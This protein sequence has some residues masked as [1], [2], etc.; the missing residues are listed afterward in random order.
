[1]FNRPLLPVPPPCNKNII[2]NFDLKQKPN[3]SSDL[4]QGFIFGDMLFHLRKIKKPNS[5]G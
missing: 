2:I 4:G 3:F 1:M 5:Y